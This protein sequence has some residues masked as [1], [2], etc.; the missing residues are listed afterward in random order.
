MSKNEQK[1]VTQHEVI[2]NDNETILTAL[3]EE[4]NTI[5]QKKS[6]L[7]E[8]EA[9]ITEYFLLLIVIESM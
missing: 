8:H 7:L 4:Y 2:E 6:V 5:L 3:K 1:H 9:I